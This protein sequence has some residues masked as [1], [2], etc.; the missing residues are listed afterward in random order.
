ME[1]DVT[2]KPI[3]LQ[4]LTGWDTNDQNSL[5]FRFLGKACTILCMLLI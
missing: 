4:F 3:I 5:S 2:F 1:D